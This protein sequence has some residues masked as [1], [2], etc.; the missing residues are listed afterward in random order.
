MFTKM[1][2]HLFTKTTTTKIPARYLIAIRD[3]N[4]RRANTTEVA[5]EKA[6]DHPVR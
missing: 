1:R 4:P 6:E 2:T 5:R 3:L